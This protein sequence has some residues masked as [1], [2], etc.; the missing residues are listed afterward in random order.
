MITIVLLGQFSVT[1]H[2]GRV[3]DLYTRRST[4]LFAFLVLEAG[5]TFHRARLA[6]QF[7][8][9]LPEPRGRKA[10]NTELWRI[11]AALKA[12]G[13]DVGAALIRRQNQVGYVR[14]PDHRIDVDAMS[15]ATEVVS[16]TDPATVDAT[17]LRIVED[18]V[19]C[20]RGDLL[21]AVY[22]DWCLLW[23]E[24]LR[25]DHSDALEFLLNVAMARQDWAAGLRHGRALLALDPLLEHVHRAVMRCHYH[26]GNRPLALRQYA[27]CEQILREELGVAPMDETR[28]IQETLLSVTPRPSRA[29]QQR[30]AEAP[31]RL[32]GGRR[33]PAQ[34]VDMAL[35]NINSAR[36]WLEDVS[37]DLRSDR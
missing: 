34:K 28:R 31:R 21:E 22:S 5:R 26:A 33:S 16:S 3:A 9:H 32:D 10:L 12:I 4:E 20:Y 2:A 25:A 15:R 8:A 29:V 30:V 19:D 11:A 36:G 13:V 27:A 17:Q 14:Q 37:R 23:R 24:S 18:A 35:A 6:E 1:G 7:W